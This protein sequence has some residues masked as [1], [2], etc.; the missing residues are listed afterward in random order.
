MIRR[1][2]QRN[3]RVKR[4][5]ASANEGASSHARTIGHLQDAGRF[6]RVES[7]SRQ[8]RACEIEGGRVGAG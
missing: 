1:A 5:N 8:L 3:P 6:V 4:R 7:G 2:I